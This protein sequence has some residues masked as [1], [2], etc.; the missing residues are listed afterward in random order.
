M[1][2]VN[3]VA[4]SNGFGRYNLVAESSPSSIVKKG[5]TLHVFLRSVGLQLFNGATAWKRHHEGAKIAVYNDRVTASLFSWLHIPPLCIAVAIITINLVGRRIGQTLDPTLSTGLQFCAKL[6]EVLMQTSLAA[7]TLG[8]VRRELLGNGLP[9]GTI[10]APA[11]TTF[12]SY[13]WSLEYWAAITSVGLGSIRIVFLLCSL[14]ASMILAGLVGPSSA[15]A[16]I[17]RTINQTMFNVH[18]FS[19]LPLTYPMSIGHDHQPL[20]D[21]ATIDNQIF[22]L[23]TNSEA[24]SSSK[25]WVA[26]SSG[27]IRRSPRRWIYDE[28]AWY[29]GSRLSYRPV[30]SFPSAQIVNVLSSCGVLVDSITGTRT[31]KFQGKVPRV[32]VTCREADM[33][34]NRSG[35][36]ISEFTNGSYVPFPPDT[37]LQDFMSISDFLAIAD[38]NANVDI[39][40]TSAPTISQPR[41][42]VLVIVGSFTTWSGVSHLGGLGSIQGC[43]VDAIWSDATYEWRGEGSEKVNV[44]SANVFDEELLGE[45]VNGY[46]PTPDGASEFIHDFPKETRIEIDPGWARRLTKFAPTI[47]NLLN[48]ESNDW[49]ANEILSVSVAAFLA[50]WHTKS[51]S[52]AECWPKNELDDLASNQ[53][54]GKLST[55]L[56]TPEVDPTFDIVCFNWLQQYN[57]LHVSKMELIWH[58]VGYNSTGTTVCLAL[59][60]LIVYCVVVLAYLIFLFV[61]GKAGSSW[62]SIAELFMLALNSRPPTHLGRTSVGVETMRTFKE[63]VSIRV[64]E[65]QECELV[66]GNS[67]TAK[68]S[69]YSKVVP[70]FRY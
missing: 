53:R 9:L 4:S 48:S 25:D 16:M 64:N 24:S 55:Y 19:D 58:G 18:Y 20:N 3:N 56:R 63:P 45:L 26:V 68:T 34:G 32:Q 2:R 39:V 35:H 29:T 1:D 23:L 66:F 36:N 7:I 51:G 47:H 49:N 5:R 13:L 52:V 44:A 38:K 50:D 27:N 54:F 31:M 41:P 67:E 65:G 60:V 12:I 46:I 40:W 21:S 10:F 42:S 22:Q 14:F 15:I 8:L 69:S 6:H 59:A 70:N 33:W 57:D 28:D 30:T 11:Q 43:S 17:P 61:T 37:G 62:D